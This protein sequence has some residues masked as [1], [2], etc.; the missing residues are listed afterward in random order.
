MPCPHPLPPLPHLF[1][2][3]LNPIGSTF[4]IHHHQFDPFPPHA[5][6][7]P[8][9]PTCTNLLTGPLL[10][11][12]PLESILH[13]AARAILLEHRSAPA[14]FPGP[15]HGS[16]PTQGQS[17]ARGPHSFPVGLQ[18]LSSPTSLVDL[19]AVPPTCCVHSR[20]RA[21]APA[22]PLPGALFPLIFASLL[23][24]SSEI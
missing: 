4:K 10:P 16:W 12:Q 23:L 3:S 9:F 5:R 15:C 21:F 18:L 7:P 14:L 1:N 19:R 17:P 13:A 20:R 24:L 2:P 6:P 8:V 11:A 22:L